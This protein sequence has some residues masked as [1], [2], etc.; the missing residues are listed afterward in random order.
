MS[1]KNALV[2]KGANFSVNKLTTVTIEE[3][4]P[5]T[6]ITISDATKTVTD[7]TQFTL[8]AT[9]TPNN[10]T[11]NVVWSTSNPSVVE[12]NDGTVTPKGIGT[13][14]ITA[15]CGN[16]TATC[17]VTATEITPNLD[18]GN[19]QMTVYSD[20]F[21]R[22]SS[23][24]SQFSVY[25]KNLNGDIPR[26]FRV[27]N[28]ITG[29]PIPLINNVGKIHFEATGIYSSYSVS[30]F[31]CDTD[32]AADSTHNDC[33]TMRYFETKSYSG[34][35][36]SIDVDVPD[37]KGAINAVAVMF[38]KKSEDRNDPD[39]N[40]YATNHNVTLKFLSANSD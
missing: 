29:G 18:F 6:G 30:I 17:V 13:A 12:V 36:V 5:C 33:C 7:L 24:D 1:A 20:V 39:P 10:T 2:I 9:K 21:L 22:S 31:W 11:D 3:E 37:D 28:D 23:S 35:S 38:L 34:S 8:T 27:G 16:Q 25:D 4:I 19:F 14:T 15:T 32:T 40:E 26:G